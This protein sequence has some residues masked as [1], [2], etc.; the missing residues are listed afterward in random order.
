MQRVNKYSFEWHRSSAKNMNISSLKLSLN[1][2]QNGHSQSNILNLVIILPLAK[3]EEKW[4]DKKRPSIL[5]IEDIV[6]SDLSTQIF[7]IKFSIVSNFSHG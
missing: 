2:M 5:N 3:Q 4:E 1:I 6:P 7:Q